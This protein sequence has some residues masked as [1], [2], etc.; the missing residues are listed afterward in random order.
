MARER[1]FEDAANIDDCIVKVRRLADGT[2]Q[3][4]DG[5]IFGKQP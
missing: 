1:P 4:K 3:T 2:I 5:R